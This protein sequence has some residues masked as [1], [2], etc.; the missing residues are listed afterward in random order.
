MA[1]RK[2]ESAANKAERLKQKAQEIEFKA[3]LALVN[4]Q[5]KT[6]PSAIG[7]VV[8]KMVEVGAMT[9]AQA[10]GLHL[11]VDYDD[12]AINPYNTEARPTLSVCLGF[13]SFDCLVDC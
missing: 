6:H 9:K 3:G 8:K 10:A 4:S 7:A 1:P 11:G 5:L 13:L 12:L 2:G